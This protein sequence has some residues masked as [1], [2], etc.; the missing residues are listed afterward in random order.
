MQSLRLFD[1]HKPVI[2]LPTA[3]LTSTAGDGTYISLK[4]YNR[5]SVLLSMNNST[6]VTGG[7]VTLKQAQDVA[8]TNEKELGFDWV[9]ANEDVLA[10]DDLVNT[11]VVSNSFTT[12][13]IN[14]K[15]SLY[16][17]DVL[18][19]DLDIDGGF[20]CVRIDVTGTV[21]STGCSIYLLGDG[22]HGSNPSAIVD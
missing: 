4:N 17:I 9:L 1:T 7:T 2:A 10:S 18:A 16:V 3:T 15:K 6:T 12:T 20:D 8:G 19:E 14:N 22:R 11:A 5:V 21:S 13:D